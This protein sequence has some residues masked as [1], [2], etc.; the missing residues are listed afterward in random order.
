MKNLKVKKEFIGAATSV[1]GIGQIKISE[2]HAAILAQA[3]RW[4][5]LEGDMPVH[6]KLIPVVEKLV[7]PTKIVEPE[8]EFKKGKKKNASFNQSN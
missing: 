4:E 5:L 6:K 2:Y 8:K 7:E 3:G 1:P